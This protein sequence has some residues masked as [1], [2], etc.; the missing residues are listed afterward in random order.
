M[1]KQI[2]EA[3]NELDKLLPTRR[4][5]TAPPA[6]LL[7]VTLQWSEL[8]WRE[9][10]GLGPMKL[11]ETQI[12][13]GLALRHRPVFVCGVHRSGTTLVQNLLDGHPQLTVLPSEGTFYTNLELKLKRLPTN[14]W[15]QYLGT[16]WLRRLVNPINQPPYWLLGKTDEITSP[17]IDFAR[18]VLAWWQQ[19]SHAEGTQWPHSAIILAYASCIN[20][21]T[22]AAWVDKTPTN[23]RFLNRIWAEFPEAKI[24]HV[25]REPIAT[26]TSRKAMEPGVTLRNALRYLNISYQVAADTAIVNDLRF[27]LLRYESLCDNPDETIRKLADFLNIDETPQLKQATTAGMPTQA[28][29]SFKKNASSGA[30]LKSIDHTQQDLLTPTDKN[31]IAVYVGDKA[32]LLGYQTNKI[33]GLNK[34]YMQFKQLFFK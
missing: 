28:N 14:Q 32:K 17:Y 16:E 2:I 25:V 24:V 4:L 30:I 27:F 31:M 7:Y 23:E 26:L 22:A 19:L 20:K 11:S 1:L 15:P 5:E 12:A 13:S 9:A 3:E 34:V 33:S 8:V 29:S 10:E 18:Y 21:L 6:D